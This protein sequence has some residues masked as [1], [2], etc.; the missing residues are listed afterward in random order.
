MLNPP[1]L[2][3]VLGKRD[4]HSV[5]IW[6]KGMKGQQ[7][8]VRWRSNKDESDWTTILV[9]LE[10]HFDHTGVGKIQ[11]GSS[12]AVIYEVGLVPES[13]QHGEAALQ[14]ELLP[15]TA[16]GT[17]RARNDSSS[18]LSFLLG[19]C[20]HRG[21]GP[22]RQGD[23][24]LASIVSTGLHR[25]SEFMIMC[26][27]QVYCDQAINDRFPF[28]PGLIGHDKV[29][30]TLEGYF[31]KYRQA[32]KLEKFSEALRHL[33]TYMIFDDHEVENNWRGYQYAAGGSRDP[34]VLSNG[35]T[36]Y[37]A[38]QAQQS[39]I[40]KIQ[41]TATQSADQLRAH[42]WWYQFSSNIADFF[43]LDT[44]SKRTDPKLGAPE[45][46]G[47]EQLLALKEFLKHENNERWKFI[48]SPIPFA[49]DTDERDILT[50]D[51]WKAYPRQRME[52][53]QWMRQNLSF[54]P[55]FL[56]GDIHLSCFATVSDRAGTFRFPCITS[57]ALNWWLFGVQDVGKRI[58]KKLPRIQE[59]P[60]P[61]N[62]D[63]VER[64]KHSS[65]YVVSL[66][67]DRVLAN[68][69]LRLKISG[70]KL[71]VFAHAAKNSNVLAIWTIDRAMLFVG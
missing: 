52:L 16:K 61:I 65:D 12:G 18:C 64:A 57:S 36:A 35:L 31:K 19:S 50:V 60:L 25:E 23:Q 20:R 6:L 5:T 49:P 7:G 4:E 22:W 55:V 37:Y 67:K 24:A 1:I 53:I 68:N 28:L 43:V 69:F 9:K 62:I 38:Y 21:Y 8:I 2:G 39:P 48:V 70:S 46:L 32:Y 54:M 41:N 58:G 27:D 26:G 47:E 63:E 10:E 3:P 17:V 33:P 71:E 13:F 11:I 15:D 30:T 29:P 51:T 40:P 42:Q 66:H 59:G 34:K 45:I 44:R 56:Q 14:W